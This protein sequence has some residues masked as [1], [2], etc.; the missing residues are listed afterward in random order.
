[1]GL[2]GQRNAGEGLRDD[3][4][5]RGGGRAGD[6]GVGELG[7]AGPGRVEVG[8]GEPDLV[9]LQ[10]VDHVR[11]PQEGVAEE[12]RRGAGG[13]DAE[14][15]GGGA[16]FQ[17]GD[18]SVRGD[19][20]DDEL[21]DADDDGGAGGAAEGEVEG[22]GRVAETAGDGVAVVGVVGGPDSAQYSVCVLVR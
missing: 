15:A 18:A 17:G 21:V 12:V 4:G 5:R 7:D 11:G 14:V 8:V 3:Q 1:M 6:D 13:V 22:G 2:G 16:V 20:G 9:V 19:D 10:V